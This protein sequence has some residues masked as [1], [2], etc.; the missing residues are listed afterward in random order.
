MD[1]KEKVKILQA[2]AKEYG[3]SDEVP[4]DISDYIDP[5]E[6]NVKSKAYQARDLMEEALAEQVMKNTGVPIPD[7]KA[8]ISKKEDFLNRIAEEIYPEMGSDIKIKPDLTYKGLDKEG[9]E[10]VKKAHGLYYPGSAKIQVA[11][12]DDL[13]RLL[14]TSLHEGGH[15]YDD[16]W[17]GKIGTDDVF[18]EPLR[19]HVKQYNEGKIKQLVKPDEAYEMIARGHHMQ[20]PGKRD[21][22][23]FGAGALKSYLKSGK[24]KSLL[25][26]ALTAGAAAMAGS[27]SD[28][29]ADVVVPGGVEGVGEGSD[30]LLSDS[31]ERDV[32][33]SRDT[34]KDDKLTTSRLK[35][36]QRMLGN[37]R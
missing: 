9:K 21:G 33:L 22:T 13:H 31:Q 15:K 1:Q 32:E 3:A 36:L 10:V 7:M 12:S 34:T 37:G 30:K 35:A 25:P 8:P 11:D 14:A 17:L 4:F 18:D 26:G 19:E 23:T 6:K 28:A 5:S 16:K 2:I 24:F 20:I 29:L 27:A